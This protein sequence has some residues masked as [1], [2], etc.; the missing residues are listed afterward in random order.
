MTLH[1]AFS[2]FIFN[3]E[4]KLLLQ[5]RAASKITFPNLWTNSCCSHPLYNDQE[6]DQS[7]EF[8]GVRRAARRKVEHELG[9]KELGLET[10]NVMGRFVLLDWFQNSD[11][12]FS[13]EIV[14]S[15]EN[16]HNKI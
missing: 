14:K 6:S 16:L 12:S 5:K 13:I 1:R 10:M 3:P 8:I 4:K 9:I 11:F 2:V 7:K 15:E